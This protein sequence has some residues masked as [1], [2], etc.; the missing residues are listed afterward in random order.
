MSQESGQATN[1]GTMAKN[2][3]EGDFMDQGQRRVLLACFL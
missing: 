3:V 2:R 1:K